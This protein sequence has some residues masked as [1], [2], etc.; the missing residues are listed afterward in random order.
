MNVFQ[1]VSVVI[2]A[3]NAEL[4][5]EK[6]LKSIQ[7]FQDVVITLDMESTDN[8]E[9]IISKYPYVKL[10]RHSFIGFGPLKNAACKLAKNDWILSLDSDE[11]MTREFENILTSLSLN[12]NVV[13]AVKRK[14]YYKGRIINGC[15]WENDFPVRLFN[16][17]KTGFNNNMVHEFI[18]EDGLK[19]IKL[20]EGINHFPYVDRTHLMQKASYYASLT[21]LKN[22]NSFFKKYFNSAFRFFRDYIIKRGFLYG[23]DGFDICRANAYGVYLKYK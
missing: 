3:K 11:E 18:I 19:K 20:S 10:F 21:T 22:Q 5:I 9:Q 12:D 4:H 16:R 8:T 15:G 23:K 1:N 2:I 17:S 7:S 14:N 13:Y 6:C